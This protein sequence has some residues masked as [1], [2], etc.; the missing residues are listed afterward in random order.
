MDQNMI[1]AENVT[2]YL[3]QT[4]LKRK[5]DNGGFLS[6]I[7]HKQPC[8][9][10]TSWAILAC[11]ACGNKT[12]AIKIARM[13][14]STLQRE[15]GRICLDEN[16][17]AAFWPTALAILAWQGATDY[18]NQYN[19][20]I[21]FLLKTTGIHYKKKADSP[22]G[23]DT[24]IQGWPWIEKTHSWI[25]PTALSIL[26]LKIAG[27]KEHARVK[28]GIRMIMDRQLDRG[29]WNYG[30]ITIFGKELFPIPDSTAIAISALV[31]SVSR[32]DIDKSIY[33]LKS[34]I[35]KI[36]APFSLGWGILGLSAWNERPAN[37]EEKITESLALQKKYGAF[38]T[39]LLSLLLIACKA[40]NGLPGIFRTES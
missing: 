21:Q 16:Y 10:A 15:D 19:Q 7:A 26:A 35:D 25:E 40:P 38:Q 9:V 8:P 6:S 31:G 33:Y 2:N 23:H 11:L 20:A 22:L 1:T 29:G 4:I 37:I 28:E 14:L 27:Y 17:T 34:Q 5:A 3:E 18:K 32:A 39:P 30:N 36:K 13:Y 24:S 12:E